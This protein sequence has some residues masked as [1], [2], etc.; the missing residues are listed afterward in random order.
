MKNILIGILLILVLTN[1]SNEKLRKELLAKDQEKLV[2]AI[3]CYTFNKYKFLKIC[4]RGFGM[5]DTTMTEY[6]QFKDEVEWVMEYL[7]DVDYEE[8][9]SVS[10]GIKLYTAYS[11]LSD[12]VEKT[13]EDVFPLVMESLAVLYKDPFEKVAL[14]MQG[15]EKAT[16]QC[17]EHGVLSAVTG[18]M[19]GLGKSVA[20]YEASKT[21]TEFLQ[22]SESKALINYYRSLLFLQHGLYYLSEQEL[23]N[24]I[25]WLDANPDVELELTKGFF[26]WN[27]LP[28]KKVYAGFHALNY[29]GRGLN[30]LAMPYK[31]DNE[32]GMEDL[33]IFLDDFEK[34]GIQNELV[35]GIEVYVYLHREQQAKAISSLKKLQDSNLLAEDE[36]ITI[37]ESIQYLENREEDKVI[38]GVYDKVF[39]TKILSSYFYSVIKKIDWET[40]LKEN[41]VPH[42][43]DM[44]I[45][46]KKMEIMS[47]KIESVTD[48][49]VIEDVK[50]N[51]KE[52][53][54]KLFDK[55]KDLL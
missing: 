13:D 34:L 10:D 31:R 52:E 25:T 50:N 23:T 39:L 53:G 45:M 15:K 11:R 48:D 9:L 40:L 7:D 18:A 12:Q 6:V 2:D 41:Q 26:D 35:W 1:C 27:N 46:M 29:L 24:N 8:S 38:N 3:H 14:L 51:I 21:N 28:D 42:A 44:I 49:Q 54:S 22:E 32:L 37:A 5:E 43:E 17:L 36:Q 33:E 19:K 16:Y 47:G 4:V 30:R 20:L 55:A